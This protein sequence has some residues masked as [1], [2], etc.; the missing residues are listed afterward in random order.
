MKKIARCTIAEKM[1]GAEE[2]G[3]GKGKGKGQ[4]ACREGPAKQRREVVPI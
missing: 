1:A 2:G 3:K 4:E